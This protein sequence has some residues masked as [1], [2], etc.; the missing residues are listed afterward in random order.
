MD[1]NKMT[2]KQFE[3]LPYLDDFNDKQC[4][5]SVEIDSIVLLP[6]RKHQDSGYNYFNVI[7]CKGDKAIGKCSGYDSFS[8]YMDGKYNRAGIDCLRGSGLMRIFL[9][10]DGYK[11]RSIFHEVRIEPD[12]KKIEEIVEM[13]ENK[14]SIELKPMWDKWKETLIDEYKGD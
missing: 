3:E 13:V 12:K 8:V 6:S 1:I 5:D 7:A 11:L 14:N 9:P 4:F 2:R 10:P